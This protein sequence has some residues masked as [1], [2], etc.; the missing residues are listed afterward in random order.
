MGFFKKKKTYDEYI[1]QLMYGPTEWYTKRDYGKSGKKF[2]AGTIQANRKLIYDKSA[3]MSN[4]DAIKDLITTYNTYHEMPF[5]RKKLQGWNKTLV[6]RKT[7]LQLDKLLTTIPDFKSLISY[8]QGTEYKLFPEYMLK[9]I[10]PSYDYDT[11]TFTFNNDLY[12]YKYDADINTAAII[13][14]SY[15]KPS[16]AK[17]FTSTI[18]CYV[19]NAITRDKKITLSI[20]PSI[21]ANVKEIKVS[22]YIYD[23]DKKLKE[24]ILTTCPIDGKVSIPLDKTLVEDTIISIQVTEVITDPITHQETRNIYTDTSL[25]IVFRYP[26]PSRRNYSDFDFYFN[27]STKLDEI[28]KKAVYANFQATFHID[29]YDNTNNVIEE[30]RTSIEIQPNDPKYET[31]PNEVKVEIVSKFTWKDHT[32]TVTQTTKVW[33]PVKKKYEDKTISYQENII[34]VLITD[35]WID[36]RLFL[37]DSITDKL[38]WY[39]IAY[40]NTSG[41]R[42]IYTLRDISSV[43]TNG[44]KPTVLTAAVRVLANG[45]LAGGKRGDIN[46][47]KT[48][49]KN[50]NYRR[51]P[52]KYKPLLYEALRNNK[53]SDIKDA[54]VTSCIN[55]QPY[56]KA[57]IREDKYYI[58]YLQTMFKFFDKEFSCFNKSFKNNSGQVYYLSGNYAD[59]WEVSPCAYRLRGVKKIISRNTLPSRLCFLGEELDNPNHLCLYC[60]VPNYIEDDGTSQTRKFNTITQYILDLTYW[61]GNYNFNDGKST[62][63]TIRIAKY[64][65]IPKIIWGSSGYKRHF[66]IHHDDDDDDDYS[67]TPSINL[68]EY[69]ESPKTPLSGNAIYNQAITIPAGSNYK[70]DVLEYMWD[71]NNSFVTGHY[72][73]TYAYDSGGNRDKTFHMPYPILASSVNNFES[74]INNQTTRCT[75]V[76]NNKSITFKWLSS[77]IELSEADKANIINF[78]KTRVGIKD[79]KGNTVIPM[80]DINIRYREKVIRKTRYIDITSNTTGV[81]NY[82]DKKEGLIANSLP[83][84]YTESTYWVSY[85]NNI[86]IF[87]LYNGQPA[88]LEYMKSNGHDKKTIFFTNHD[89]GGSVETRFSYVELI[90]IDY[91]Y[92]YRVNGVVIEGSDEKWLNYNSWEFKGIVEPSFTPPMPWRMWIRVPLYVQEAVLTSILFLGFRIEFQVKKATTL[93]KVIGIVVTVV[94]IVLIVV[95]ALTSWTGFG[96]PL[97]TWGKVILGIGLSMLGAA[98]GKA[99]LSYLGMAFSLW[100]GYG[101]IQATTAANIAAGASVGLETAKSVLSM[102]SLVYSTANNAYKLATQSKAQAKL[103][104]QQKEQEERD[105]LKNDREFQESLDEV[106]LADYDIPKSID[107]QLDLYYFI[108]YGGL[109]YD[110]NTVEQIAYHSAEQPIMSETFDRFK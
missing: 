92:K 31:R 11:S 100:G 39:F 72:T 74:Y 30:E 103:E 75:E 7:E 85:L 102:A 53:D 16:N 59:R 86:N 65:K 90:R 23:P 66:R 81:I 29:P 70:R 3:K 61:Y 77:G 13:A 45:G 43:N 54:W 83:K 107:E 80:T 46:L 104:K 64:S 109:M 17:E 5:V 9:Q 71:K 21:T 4:Y 105:R 79:R 108:A 106:N 33:N 96:I 56:L 15:I 26:I 47:Q 19:D 40:Y 20:D 10:F 14:D 73:G 98:Y 69:K 91:I 37:L 67:V 84:N 34:E 60:F 89:F 6:T 76:L 63:W 12:T 49:R 88:L 62:D 50:K 58:K 8:E 93:F 2:Y 52:K 35:M 68:G 51:I 87:E 57:S 18:K 38:E 42:S 78:T 28:V 82:G 97:M 95:G 24:T 25:P 22:Y 36:K 101:M 99:F 27:P 48:K 1:H 32:R 41:K 110:Y 44:S 55:F 94:G